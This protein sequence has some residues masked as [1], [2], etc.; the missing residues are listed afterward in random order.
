L[1]AQIAT[2]ASLFPDFFDAGLRIK[3]NRGALRL[4]EI[5]PF[6]PC[7]IDFATNQGRFLFQNVFNNGFFC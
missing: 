7:S 1:R 4:A 6:L 2:P 5:A 3:S